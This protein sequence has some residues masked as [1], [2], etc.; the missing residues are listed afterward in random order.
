MPASRARLYRQSPDDTDVG[1]WVN[2]SWAAAGRNG[3][4][5]R[6][7]I[8]SYDAEHHTISMPGLQIMSQKSRMLS[9]EISIGRQFMV[10]GS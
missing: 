3:V 1:N 10:P 6:R 9:Q 5:L 4:R 2:R 8:D 7:C